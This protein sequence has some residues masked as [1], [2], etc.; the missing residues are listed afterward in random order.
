MSDSIAPPT[1]AGPAAVHLETP[2]PTQAVDGAPTVPATPAALG[3]TDEQFEKYFDAKTGSYN[4]AAHAREGDFKLAQKTAK[5]TS[6]PA[7]PPPTTFSTT[8]CTFTGSARPN[9]LTS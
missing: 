6:D 9:T 4:W 1:N 7:K 8:R 2:P 3:V 5:P